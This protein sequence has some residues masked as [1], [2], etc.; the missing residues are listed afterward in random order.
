M[1]KSAKTAVTERDLAVLLTTKQ[2]V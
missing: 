2:R 1:G